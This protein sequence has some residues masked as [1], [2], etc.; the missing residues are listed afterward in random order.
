VKILFLGGQKSGKS[1][2]ALLKT[3][4]IAKKKP[5]Y[6][7]TYIDN[8]NDRE[9]KKRIKNHSLERKDRF[10]LIE[11]GIHLYKTIKKSRHKTILIDCLSIWI[12]N[13]LEQK[14]AQK[15]ILKEIKKILK[16]KKD[17]V[18]II[19]DI[20]NSTIAI[21]KSTREFVD[22]TGLVAQLVAKKSKKV[23]QAIYGIQKRIK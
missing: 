6:I 12:F 1:H 19:N 20:S 15:E 7:A 14:T 18:F 22:T 3:L 23:Y 16:L 21:D 9:M 10:D 8:F 2:L 13:K 11:Q 17:I 4:Q 5:L